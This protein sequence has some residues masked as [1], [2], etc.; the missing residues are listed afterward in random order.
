M[1]KLLTLALALALLA[2]CG[3]RAAAPAASASLQ[4][5]LAVGK[6]FPPFVLDHIGSAR[7]PKGKVIVLNVWAT[8]CPPCRREMPGLERLSRMLDASRFEVIGMSTDDDAALAS[9]FLR[10][11]GIHFLN[12]LDQGGT[13]SRRL[14]L[15]V[16]PDT[17][18]IGADGTLLHRMT[19]LHEWDS[20]EM[21]EALENL[22]RHQAAGALLAGGGARGT[23]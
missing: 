5:E 6:A 22:H 8:W 1:A 21:V 18:I 2:G 7:L 23:R 11:N 10:E 4:S 12:F 13:I 16:Y 20:A 19:G 15:R 9:E 14:G 17:F 3:E